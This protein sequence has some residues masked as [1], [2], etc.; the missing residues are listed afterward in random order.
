MRP[1]LYMLAEDGRT[2]IPTEDVLE[3]ADW[4][5]RSTE[6][7][8]LL[9]TEVPGGIVSTV[10][11]GID[12]NWPFDGPP[13]LWETMMFMD[14]NDDAGE[15]RRYATYEEAARGHGEIVKRALGR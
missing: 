6:Q 5:E 15:M 4:L 2:P 3:W 1:H 9:Q 7:R 14:G 8:I 11:L 10:F 13:R 12:H